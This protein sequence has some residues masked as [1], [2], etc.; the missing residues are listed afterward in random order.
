V[1]RSVSVLV[2]D[3]LVVSITYGEYFRVD[4]V[5]CDVSVRHSFHYSLEASSRICTR[6]FLG[7]LRLSAFTG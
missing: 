3:L 1:V 7:G 6:E 4:R 5:H 2:L